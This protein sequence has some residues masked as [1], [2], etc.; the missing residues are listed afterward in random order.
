MSFVRII[1]TVSTMPVK[2]TGT[3]GIVWIASINVIKNPLWMNSFPRQAQI[4]I[5]RFHRPLTGSRR[6]F[7]Y[8]IRQHVDK[9][10]GGETYETV[11][12]TQSGSL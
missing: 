7:Q 3:I 2:N 12:H 4:R 5:T 10:K 11:Y 1:E 8:E 9:I 6:M